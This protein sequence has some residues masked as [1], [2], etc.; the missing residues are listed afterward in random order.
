MNSFPFLWEST[1]RGAKKFP[2][3]ESGEILKLLHTH[4]AILFKGFQIDC[5]EKLQ[6]VV[7]GFH[8]KPMQYTGGTSPR[9]RL[10]GD[11]YTSTEYRSDQHIHLHSELSHAQRWP[12]YLC[13]CCEVPPRR[14]G[15]TLIA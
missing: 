7:S 5:A 12:R 11:I 3:D 2:F 14:A 8:S 15:N 10:Y 1:E 4:G 9:T 13:F 6:E